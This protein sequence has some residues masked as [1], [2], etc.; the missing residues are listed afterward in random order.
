MRERGRGKG[1]RRERASQFVEA[2]SGLSYVYAVQTFLICNLIG[3]GRR[4]K[5]WRGEGG[6]KKKGRGEGGRRM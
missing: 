4:R 5:R 6:R 2:V 1:G 3:Q